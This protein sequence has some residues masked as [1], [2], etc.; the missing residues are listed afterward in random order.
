MKQPAQYSKVELKKLRTRI[1]QEHVPEHVSR[2]EFQEKLDVLHELYDNIAA[3]YSKQLHK[4]SEIEDGIRLFVVVCKC[5][6]IRNLK[7][8][9][10]TVEK[11]LNCNEIIE[12]IQKEIDKEFEALHSWKLAVTVLIDY[13]SKLSTTEPGITVQLSQIDKIDVQLKALKKSMPKLDDI[14]D[15]FINDNTIRRILFLYYNDE[16]EIRAILATMNNSY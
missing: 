14:A 9:D 5:K 4:L 1:K 8:K 13:I 6:A 2:E 11:I 10:V 15:K 3:E 16:D 12:T 7:R